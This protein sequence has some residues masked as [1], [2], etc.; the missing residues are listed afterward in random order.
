MTYAYDPQGSWTKSHQIRLNRKQ[1]GFTR[2]DLLL[3]ADYCNL[4][5]AKAAA[6]L[7]DTIEGFKQFASLADML[8]VPRR[9][10]ETVIA[11]QRTE[12]LK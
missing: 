5:H 4:S 12:A 7:D 2:D 11:N 10:K 8:A 6:I 9:L 1:S 3:F